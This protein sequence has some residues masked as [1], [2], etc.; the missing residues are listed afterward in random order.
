MEGPGEKLKDV[1]ETGREDREEVADRG[2]DAWGREPVSKKV[3]SLSVVGG[4][5]RARRREW[6]TKCI[7]GKEEEIS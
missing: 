2:V 1:F 7:R 6:S 3:I 5:K 4:G